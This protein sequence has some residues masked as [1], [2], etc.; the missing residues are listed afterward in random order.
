MCPVEPLLGREIVLETS[1]RWRHCE[2]NVCMQY[3]AESLL[4]E[5]ICVCHVTRCTYCDHSV[6]QLPMCSKSACTQ[7][8][9][10]GEGLSMII[11]DRL[12]E[13][14]EMIQ[15]NFPDFTIKPIFNE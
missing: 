7:L 13:V 5:D 12:T 8:I 9:L 1:D 10:Q 15:T 2:V 6:I 3:H 14:F 4:D 11:I